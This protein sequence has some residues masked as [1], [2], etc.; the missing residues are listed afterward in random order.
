[1]VAHH[2]VDPRHANDTAP[3]KLFVG[4]LSWQTSSEKLREYFGMFGTVTDVL[5]M[6]DPIT[7]VCRFIIKQF[8]YLFLFTLHQSKKKKI[9]CHLLCGITRSAVV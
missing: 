1:V 4:G 2:P 8:I 6:K 7:Q 9:L 5:I 3:G